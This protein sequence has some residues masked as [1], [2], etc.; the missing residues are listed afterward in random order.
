M[1]FRSQCIRHEPKVDQDTLVVGFSENNN[2]CYVDLSSSHRDSPIEVFVTMQPSGDQYEC[3]VALIDALGLHSLNWKPGLIDRQRFCDVL[4]PGTHDTGTYAYSD[5]NINDLPDRYVQCQDCRSD[6]LTQLRN[7]IRYFDLRVRKFVD[8][9]YGDNLRLFH[10]DG[11][12]MD[13]I[14][15]SV[16]LK[17]SLREALSA[18]ETFLGEIQL[19]LSLLQ[20]GARMDYADWPKRTSARMIFKAIL[21]TLESRG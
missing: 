11:Y 12:V 14:P 3:V 20:S 2:A 6:F 18:V 1:R 4:L 8:G 7:G 10:G 13:V 15:K 17:V 5:G 21:I 19:R 9:H 16:Y